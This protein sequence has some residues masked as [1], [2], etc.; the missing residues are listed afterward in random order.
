LLDGCDGSK[1]ERK[2]EKVVEVPACPNDDGD[3]LDSLLDGCEDSFVELQVRVGI[4]VRVRVRVKEVP[5]TS[6]NNL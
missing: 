3:F 5:L 6:D 1:I 2:E 4:R